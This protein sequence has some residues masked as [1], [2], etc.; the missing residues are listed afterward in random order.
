MTIPIEPM[1][2]EAGELPVGDAWV[3]EFKWDGVR[4]IVDVGTDSPRF[5]SR[6]GNE[7]TSSFPELASLAGLLPAAT[8]L[9]AEIVT[10]DDRGRPDFG[11]LQ[12]RLH[13]SGVVPA[14]VIADARAVIFAFDLLRLDG[15]ELV[16]L[17]WTERRRILDA[18]EIDHR[19]LKVPPV[20]DAAGSETLDAARALG[21]EGVMA[22]QRMATYQPGRRSG[23]WRK[24]KLVIEDDFV[25]CGWTNGSGR[26]EATVGSLLLGTHDADGRLRYVGSVGSGLS[27]ADRDRWLD[28]F[29]RSERPT[30]PFGIGP[31][32]PV[33]RFVEPTQVVRVRFS[34]WTRD[35]VLRH[36]SYIGVRIDRPAE[37]VRTPASPADTGLD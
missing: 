23:S 16:E 36:P 32:R 35:L 27:D 37:Q 22:K 2:A 29:S 21:L 5:W 15:H 4:T 7:F 25:V 19:E 9:D 12:H 17:P 3:H 34:Q 26:L 28:H 11:L 6:N 20:F 1:L 31:R 13:R 18:L 30:D 24:V 14:T 33:G 8:V 10:L